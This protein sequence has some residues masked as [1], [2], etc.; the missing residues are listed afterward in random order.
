MINAILTGIFNVVTKF[1]SVL[2]LP[3]NLL[4][5]NMLPDFNNML[6]YVASF[7]NTCLTYVGFII[8]STFI[9]PEVISFLILFWVFKLTF[10]LAVYAI[11][12]VVKWYN[13]LKV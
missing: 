10:P 11:K 8:D 7:F 4:V 3:I 1:I 9:S 12:L 5:T 2:L 6:S 13:N